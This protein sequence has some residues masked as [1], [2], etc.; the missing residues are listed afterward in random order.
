[1]SDNAD[2]IILVD[3]ETGEEITLTLFD[4]FEY[5]GK[6]YIVCMAD[7]N[8]DV[9]EDLSDISIMILR[10]VTNKDGESEL[11]TIHDEEEDEVY[12]YYDQLLEESIED[13]DES[14]AE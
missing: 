5:K 13:E 1:M 14:E 9:D 12:D 4:A 8:P 6:N 3:E 11:V 2:S 10:E 7:G